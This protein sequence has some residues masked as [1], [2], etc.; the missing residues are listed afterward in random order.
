LILYLG[1]VANLQGKIAGFDHFKLTG[2]TLN[3]VY[4][5]ETIIYGMMN[6]VTMA[7]AFTVTLLLHVQLAQLEPV[8]PGIVVVHA[9]AIAIPYARRVMVNVASETPPILVVDVPVCHA[10]QE[11]ISRRR[12]MEY[13]QR[14]L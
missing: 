1:I 2:V 9:P 5:S 13:A 14:A 3:T 10:R 12:E 11:N 8:A 6:I 7:T 4:R